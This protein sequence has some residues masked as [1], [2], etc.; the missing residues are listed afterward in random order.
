MPPA[1]TQILDMRT[2]SS[3]SAN[4]HRGVLRSSPAVIGERIMM[5][6][7]WIPDL[8]RAVCRRTR[9]LGIMLL[10]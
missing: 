7:R 9:K 2:I 3:A 10:C 4:M 5:R 6:N 8:L 1:V